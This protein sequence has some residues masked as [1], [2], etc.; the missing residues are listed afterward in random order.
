MRRQEEY[1]AIVVGSGMTGGWAAKEL[2]EAGLRTLVLEA[3]PLVVPERDYVE[4]VRPYDMPYRGLNDRKALEAEQP[5][6]RECYACDE[7]ARKFFVNDIENPYTTGEGKPFKWIRGRQVGGKSIMWARQSY[8]LSDLDLEANAREGVGVDWPIRYADLEPWYDHVSRFVGIT[9]QAE[10]LPQL[11]DGP[12]LPPM[13][14]T[15]VEEHTRDAIARGWGDTRMLTIGRAAVLTEDRDGRSACHYCG[16]CHRGCITRS[17][18]SSLNA[19]LPAAEATG[20]LTL[21]PDS[22]VRSIIWDPA[23]GRVTGA[24]VIDRT[25]GDELE[26]YGRIVM[27]GAGA[28][29]STRI[30]LNSTSADF[31][32]GLAN[33]SGVLGK[34]L[35]DHTM[36]T[37]AMATFPGWE[38]YD[39]VGSRPN[40]IYIP[41]FRNVTEP[42]SDFLRGYGYQGS[43]TRS[44]W[45]RGAD[46][47]GFG[48]AYKE[49][50]SRPGPWEFWLGAFGEC[51][52]R[53]S[54]YVELDP[55]RTDAWG[56]PA[57]RIHCEW[58]DNE[59]SMMADAV[60][61]AVEML[62]AAGARDIVPMTEMGDPGLTIHEMGTARMGRDPATSVLNGFNQSWDVPNLFVI[63]GAAMTSSACQNPSLTYMALT[64]R[65]C[66]YAVEARNRGEL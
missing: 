32:D 27:L 36:N 59:R 55:D 4:H 19:T 14:M 6:Q 23:R 60:D 12:F 50:L 5:V 45:G 8:R 62:E 11:P 65:A 44:G 7:M 42:T 28:L 26:F 57:L 3:G 64:A 29:E 16:P 56:I 39:S 21:R 61:R 15:C 49:R 20:R 24:R 43:A 1:D 40:G 2:T 31:P 10:G 51:L 46:E 33:S 17:Y 52:P 22:V 48:A 13:A 9:G 53:E 54:N 63:D 47:P 58:S 38:A 37:G 25:T 41:R 34:Y 66:A 35:M 18:F 30:L